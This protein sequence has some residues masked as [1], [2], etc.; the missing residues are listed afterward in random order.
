VQNKLPNVAMYVRRVAAATGAA[1]RALS[2][3]VPLL[4]TTSGPDR[5]RDERICWWKEVE[6]FEAT[7]AAGAGA[8][9]GAAAAVAG[10]DGALQPVSAASIEFLARV[11]ADARA[12][13]ADTAGLRSGGGGGK[14]GSGRQ[15]YTLKGH[16]VIAYFDVP[17]RGQIRPAHEFRS[18]E[19]WR[20]RHAA[21]ASSSSSSSSLSSSSSTSAAAVDLRNNLREEPIRAGPHELLVEVCTVDMKDLHTS[22]KPE[23]P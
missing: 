16:K 17:P 22:P 10:A 1:R 13:D 15:G 8:G 2:A 23:V 3:V 21:A 4:F 9:D 7:L 6:A 14:G 5:G 12:R 11:T 18:F 19:D 20:L